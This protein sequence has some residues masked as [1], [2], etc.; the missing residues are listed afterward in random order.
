MDRYIAEYHT[1]GNSLTGIVIAGDIS[2][3]INKLAERGYIFTLGE[4]ERLEIW[5]RST[6]Y[7]YYGRSLTVTRGPEKMTEY[8]SL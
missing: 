6:A 5:G 7:R 4:R 1:P 8:T 2:A 3:L